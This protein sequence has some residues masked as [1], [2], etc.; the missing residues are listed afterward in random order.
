MGFLATWIPQEF[1]H[2]K[3]RTCV[4]THFGPSL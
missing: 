1:L 4:V 3:A 2:K